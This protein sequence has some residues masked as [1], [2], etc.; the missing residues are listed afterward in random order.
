LNTRDVVI[1]AGVRAPIGSFLGALKDV[2]AQTL[3]ARVIEE[4]LRRSGVEGGHIDE[5]VMGN[6]AGTESRSNIAREAMLETKLP[7]SIPAYTVGKACASGIK[8]I[9][10]GATTIRAG[11]ADV[12]VVGGLE[13]M[14]RAPYILQGARTG[15]RMR[16]AELTDSLLFVLDGMGMTAERLADKYQ[17]SRKEQDEFACQSQKLAAQAQQ[18]G[19]FD[20]QILPIAVPQRKGDPVVVKHDEGVKP[21]TTLEVLGTLRPTFKEGGS[22]TAGNSSTINDGAAALVLASAEKARAMGWK[23]LAKVTAWA[24]AGC[25]PAIMGIGPVPAT[26]KLLKKTGM[27]LE[28]FDLVELNEAFAVQVLAVCREMS[29]KPERLNVNGGA[30]ALGHPVG[31]SGS[32]LAVKLVYEMKRRQAGMGL[33]SACIGGGQGL[34]L[35][36][37]NVN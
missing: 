35:A 1:L 3:G 19:R 11:E 2:R 31:A 36:I 23:P 33:V 5:V 29:F 16:H 8:S 22:V 9:I 15:F 7:W 28:D 30:I 24:A 12:V 13:S 26:Q 4:A 20:E 21:N 14:S 37:E 32:I 25:D 34:S 17:I 18:A 10:M 27:K 6:N